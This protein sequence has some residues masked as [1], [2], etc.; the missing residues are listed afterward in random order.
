MRALASEASC[1]VGLPYKVF[2]SRDALLAQLVARE[3]STLREKLRTWSQRAGSRT[4]AENLDEFATLLL[5][6]DTP[7]LVHA[8]D[9]GDE[10]FLRLIDEV[11]RETGLTDTFETVLAAYLADEQRRGRIGAAVDIDA[12]AF[13]VLGAV[14]NLIT[15]GSAFPVP[16]RATLATY[17]RSIAEMSAP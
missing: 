17:L 12:I 7:A 5:E 3:L 11:S 2:E 13:F 9:E 16:S 10:S 14:H 1:A 8:N 15:A 4:V 6:S